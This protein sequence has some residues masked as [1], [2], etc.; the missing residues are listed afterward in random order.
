[1]VLEYNSKQEVPF[2]FKQI[3]REDLDYYKVKK[4][5][6]QSDWGFD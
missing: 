5:N 2:C 6:K 3:N 1:M 4:G